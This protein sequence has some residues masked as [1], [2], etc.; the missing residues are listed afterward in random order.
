MRLE[1]NPRALCY[2]LYC[3]TKEEHEHMKQLLEQPI[4]ATNIKS[5]DNMIYT[6]TDSVKTMKTKLNSL[7]GRMA[8]VSK[9]YIVIHR[10]KKPIIIF[11]KSIVAIEK[12]DDNTA[13]IF[14][15]ENVTF[16]ADEKYVDVIKQLI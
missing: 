15:S 16:Y 2:N 8:M 10:A 5:I 1:F 13:I 14:C 6:D 12:D 3:D 4:T 11:K 7:Y 9:E